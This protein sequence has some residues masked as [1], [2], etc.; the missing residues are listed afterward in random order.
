LLVVAVEAVAAV[1]AVVLVAVFR[2]FGYARF[3]PGQFGRWDFFTGTF[4][5]FCWHAGHLPWISKGVLSRFSIVSRR[6]RWP[7][8]LCGY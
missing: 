4:L 2:T 3:F 7:S 1:E 5:A 8:W 6:L